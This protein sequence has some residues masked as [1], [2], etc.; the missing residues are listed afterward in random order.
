MEMKRGYRALAALFLLILAPSTYAMKWTAMASTSEGAVSIAQD[1]GNH[2]GHRASVWIRTVFVTP[3]LI[4]GKSASSMQARWVIDCM[5][6]TYE[7][8]SVAMFDARGAAISTTAVKQTEYDIRPDTVAAA[9]QQ[10]IC[11]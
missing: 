10:E 5:L 3:R 11:K 8:T 9:I 1:G 6:D 4:A 2:A 7:A